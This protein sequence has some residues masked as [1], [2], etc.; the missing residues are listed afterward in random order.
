M[1]GMKLAHYEITS[2]LGSG[3]MGD[4]YQATDLKLGRSVAIKFLP[5]AFSHDND[6]VARFEREA[7]VLASL[8]HSNI[9]AIFGLEES[10]ERKFLVMELVGGETLAERIKRGPIPIDESVGIA[11]QICEALEAAHE[12]GII[13]RDLKPAN[14][15]IT[16]DGKLKVL[17]FGLAKAFEAEASKSNLSQ[18]P[19]L[20]MAATNAGVILGSAS[21]MSPEQVRG[22][23]VDRRTDIFAFG[24]VFYEMLTGTQAFSGEDVADILSAVLRT[25][26]DWSR[27]PVD[28][29]MGIRKLLLRCLEKDLTNRRRDAGDLRIEI[30]DAMS[31][32]TSHLPAAQSAQESRF[33]WILAVLMGLAFAVTAVLYFREVRPAP[34][35][36]MR[37]EINTP[38]TTWVESIA[39]SPD[40]QKIVFAAAVD[41]RN[42]RWLRTLD[43]PSAR[44]LAG[45][46]DGHYPFWSPDSRSIGFFSNAKLMRLDVDHGA[47]QTLADAPTGRGGTW[48]RDGIILFSQN[49]V[50][51]IF[52]LPAT[53]GDPVPVTT[54]NGQ[55]VR[56][57]HFPQFLPDGRH[58][59]YH[60]TGTDEAGGI[61]IGQ[62][63]GPETHR[64][65]VADAAAVYASSGELLFVRQ[66]I[67]F[68]QSLNLANLSL[69][70]NPSAVVEQVAFNIPTSTAALSTSAA[71]PI[72][73]RTGSRIQR[74]FVWVDRSGKEIEKVGAAD[75]GNPQNPSLSPDG[76]RIV[77]DRRNVG[78]QDLWLFDLTRSVLT[79][80]T[81]DPASENMGIWSPDGTRVAF[82]SNRK[83][84]YGAYDLYM[85]A[86]NG[87]GIDELLVATPQTKVVGDW[88]PDGRFL[89][90]R[91]LDP[92]TNYDLW[93]LPMDGERKP[94]PVLQ[95][96]FAERDGQF[97]P[98]G[99]WIAY[100]SDESG[101]FEIYAQPFPG[102][103]G[104]VQIST[105]GGAQVRW[106]HDGKEIF[107]IGAD[108]RLVAVPIT[109]KGDGT[110][111]EPG[112]P[113]PLFMTHIGGSIQTPGKQQYVVS[114]DGQRFL[115]DSVIE[116]GIAPITVL[117]NWHP[118]RAG[119]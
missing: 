2:H 76:R 92:K 111:L 86:A 104:K 60:V 83:G 89:L 58:F 8:N 88:S 61:F 56:G 9:A 35:P 7:R 98:D 118:E 44:S 101:R 70:G 22:R 93:A 67:L 99:K 6:R 12:K 106:R 105:G 13:H 50:S 41:G 4:V 38:P 109:F 53:G 26:P 90:Y 64:L 39:I 28:T 78:S 114:A 102:P 110:M 113:V 59:F 63:D 79:R 45:T 119:K 29:P 95:T 51:P 42:Q 23:R 115:M 71:G 19:T 31:E 75:P 81:T 117:L 14:I 5:E 52:R 108:D 73:Y 34:A 24:C 48:N 3:G 62:I 94:F 107:Y 77:I 49:G 1:I 72:I 68:A 17:D 36:E 40:G 37:L 112:K 66:G 47:T 54:Q 16:P 18:S 69:V 87:A 25:E 15:K 74:Q 55:Q 21:Y 43:S 46:D 84:P 57:H 80:F 32:K 11:K 97:S 10:G 91:S 20:S 103:G 96:P 33:A 82:Q 27:F 85:K 116:Q 100:Q 65:T 30:A